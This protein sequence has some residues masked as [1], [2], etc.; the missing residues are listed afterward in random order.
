M[1]KRSWRPYLVFALFTCRSFLAVCLC[2]I[3]AAKALLVF[4]AD[5]SDHRWTKNARNTHD[6]HTS[7]LELVG[8]SSS[9]PSPDKLLNN[10]APSSSKQ[11]DAS[12]AVLQRF[13]HISIFFALVESGNGGCPGG[14]LV[15]S[16][17]VRHF[18]FCTKRYRY[19][20]RIGPMSHLFHTGLARN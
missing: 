1:A 19:H 8:S 16:V 17:D 4:G 12:P 9:S 15:P 14:T 6:E 7:L 10:A 2:T 11:P 20:A 13:S 3:P 5:L 18:Q